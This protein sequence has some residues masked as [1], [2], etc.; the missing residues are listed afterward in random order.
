M[1]GIFFWEMQWIP[2][3]TFWC[4]QKHFMS[5][6]MSHYSIFVGKLIHPTYFHD[7]SSFL[8]LECFYWSFFLV[9]KFYNHTGLHS[10]GKPYENIFWFLYL[11]NCWV[12]STSEHFILSP[13]AYSFSQCGWP[14]L[15]SC[16]HWRFSLPTLW[17]IQG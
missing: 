10:V 16:S 1:S 15:F 12:N 9:S 8:L 14:L 11:Q 3:F 4:F 17:L 2:C 6:C 7:L 13:F 5:W